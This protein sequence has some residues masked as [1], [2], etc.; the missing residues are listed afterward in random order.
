M[1]AGP[2]RIGLRTIKTCLA[3]MLCILLFQ[4]LD[5]DTPMIACL[6][7]VFAMREDVS[8]TISFGTYRIVG[9]L[10]GGVLALVYILTFRFF[11]YNFYVELLLIPCLIAFII[12]FSDGLNFNPGIIGAC[13]TFFII[14]LTVPETE[15]F[16]YAIA[17]I[18]DTV[19][20][21]LVAIVVNHVFPSH[22]RVKP[23]VP[24]KTKEEIITEQ[25]AE[26][27]DLKHQLL[28]NQ[29]KK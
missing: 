10:L 8:T 4:I 7:A 5:R 11:N 23:L 15:S 18:M 29:T 2:F 14:V 17:R 22:K 13:A 3:V 16:S 28:E 24:L 26:I 1:I 9:N 27:N 19:I 12:I 21:T 20:G 25:Q 6:A